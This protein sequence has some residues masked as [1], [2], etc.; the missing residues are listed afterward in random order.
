MSN[1][2]VVYLWELSQL[3]AQFELAIEDLE[4]H[5]RKIPA[6]VRMP[7]AHIS[8][9]ARESIE[10]DVIAELVLLNPDDPA[11]AHMMPPEGALELLTRVSDNDYAT[12]AEVLEALQSTEL[13]AFLRD[14]VTIERLLVDARLR[15]QEHS[16]TGAAA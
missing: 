11:H 7:N 6:D 15:A 13:R 1:N 3:L 12:A 16:H 5:V 10:K 8:M 14:H 4:E 2:N 9:Y